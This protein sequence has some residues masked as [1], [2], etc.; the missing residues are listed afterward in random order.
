ML[1]AIVGAWAG[2]A[3]AQ[4][5]TL[6]FA[7]A[8]AA[9]DHQSLSLVEFGRL[10]EDY[11]DGRIKVDVA[12]AGV[13]GGER[14]VAEGIQLGT[15]DGAILGGILQNFDPAMAIL[16]FPFLFDD[17]AHV[18]RVMDGEV[19][20]QISERLVTNTGIR[21][22]GY[23]MRTPRVLTTNSAVTSLADIKGQS[24][25]VPEMRAH[26][27]TWR[28]LGAN[29]TPMAF[30]EVYA[31]LQLGTVGGQ[32]NPLGVI[33]A[34]RFYEVASHLAE[35][36]HLV[37]FMLITISETV[38]SNISSEDQEALVRAAAAASQYNEITLKE[39]SAVW[40]ADVKSSMT[41][42]NPDMAE[43]RAAV[44]G[45]PDTFYDVEGFRAL[46]D[47]IRSESDL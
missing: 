27:E 1:G 40:D 30:T 11:T 18:R 19:G 9:G 10:V 25:R 4:E 26:L 22:L 14:D 44:A 20:A 37:G 46:Y 24:I 21:P 33:H 29:P 34:N 42:T 12:V 41:T 38:F 13:L 28:A 6:T 5:Q 3:A 39:Q 8:Y 23:I 31:A 45:V 2:M 43:W 16:E 7:S 15:V 47:A 36:N 35:T 32:E 17:T